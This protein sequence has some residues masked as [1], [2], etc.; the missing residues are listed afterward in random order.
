MLVQIKSRWSSR[1][2]FETEVGASLDT[3]G[4][5]LGAAVRIAY[6]SGADLSGAVLRDAVL[7]GRKVI[8]LVA[9]VTRNDGYEFFAWRFE[10]G[11]RIIAGCRNLTLAEF[12][13]HVEREYPGTD[14]ARETLAILDFCERRFV[15]TPAEAA[16]AAA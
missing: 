16:Q 3:D 12:R 14:K 7:S 10:D 11:D 2:I 15:D 8:A 9:R 13:A 5:R 6:K 1:I 4:L